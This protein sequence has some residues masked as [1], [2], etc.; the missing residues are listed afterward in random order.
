MLSNTLNQDSTAILE[1]DGLQWC[2]GAQPSEMLLEGESINM[3][4]PLAASL[5]DSKEMDDL[6]TNDIESNQ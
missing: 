4:A 1:Q 6:N 5:S 2:S 3:L